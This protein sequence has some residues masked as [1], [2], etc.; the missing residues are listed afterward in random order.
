MR[1]GW[2]QRFAAA[3]LPVAAFAGLSGAPATMSQ[4][5]GDRALGQ[6]LS[7]ECVT[8]HQLSGRFDGIPPI[9]GWPEESF[10]QIMNEYRD[11]KRNHPVMQTIAK[12]LSPEEISALA[13]YFGSMKPAP[14]TKPD[15][16]KT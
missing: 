9:V 11:A 15:G 14:Q 7:S 16:G 4:A 6:Y 5:S 3:A 13:A 8:C 10:V 1:E 12:R 2:Y